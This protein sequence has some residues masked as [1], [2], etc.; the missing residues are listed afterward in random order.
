MDFRW[1]VRVPVSV[2]ILSLQGPLG[3]SFKSQEMGKNHVSCF[4]KWLHKLLLALFYF[5]LFL[6]GNVLRASLGPSSRSGHRMVL[7][8]KQLIVFG[9][10]HDNGF[11]YKYFNDVHIFDLDNR[12]W[13]KIEP[14]GS[15]FTNVHFGIYK[16]INI[17]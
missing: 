6:P 13:R 10:Y 2:S 17:N 1:R 4:R 16:F 11:D 14:A 3:V 12:K 15:H 7:S 9:G 8:K 5:I